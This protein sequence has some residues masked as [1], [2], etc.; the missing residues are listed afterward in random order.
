MVPVRGTTGVIRP[1]SGVV[2]L[3]SGAAITGAAASMDAPGWLIAAS[4]VELWF[5]AA[6]DSVAALQPSMAE[7]AFTVAADSTAADTAKASRT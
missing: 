7:A 3:V 6:V 2:A 1:V 4:A 5:E